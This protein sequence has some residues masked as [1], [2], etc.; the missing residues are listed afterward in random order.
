[1][2]ITARFSLERGRQLKELFKP[3]RLVKL[4]RKL[5]KDQ[6]RNLDIK[7]FHDYYDFNYSIESRVDAI[8]ASILSGQYRAQA[9]I[10]YRAEKKMGICRH[11]MIPS[12][13][14]A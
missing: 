11:L 4:W 2:K 9:P 1:M 3:H 12:P 5:V 6:L 7:D 10:I 8:V 14:D 13:S